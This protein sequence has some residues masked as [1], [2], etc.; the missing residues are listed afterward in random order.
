M[1]EVVEPLRA[2]R[3]RRRR[4]SRRLPRCRMARFGPLDR[5]AA[6]RDDGLRAR[7]GAEHLPVPLRVPGGGVA[8]RP[9]GHADPPRTRTASTSSAPGDLVCF[10]SGPDGAHKVTNRT[11]EHRPRRDALDEGGD[12]GRRLPRQ[13]QDRR[14][15]GRRRGQAPLPACA[16]PSTTGTA[17]SDAR[18]AAS[19]GRPRPSPSSSRVHGRERRRPRSRAATPR[20]SSR[21]ARR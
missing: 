17:S 7:P 8:A 13:R 9:R 10:P 4:R 6:A 19:R 20:R 16:P 14:L 11:A 21:S 1:S 18:T 5:R 2:P 15:V 3:R 12:R